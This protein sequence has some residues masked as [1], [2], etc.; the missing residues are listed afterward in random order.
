M[1]QK[2]K[3]II[4]DLICWSEEYLEGLVLELEHGDMDCED[5]ERLSSNYLVVGNVTQEDWDELNLD[6]DFMEADI[7]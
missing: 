4:T 6:M 7:I 5:E 1:N 3:K 2:T